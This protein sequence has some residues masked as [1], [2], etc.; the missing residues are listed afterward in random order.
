MNWTRGWWWLSQWVLVL[1]RDII[2][3]VLVGLLLGRLGETI[4]GRV[5]SSVPLDHPHAKYALD[6]LW[7]HLADEGMVGE[8]MPW[9]SQNCRRLCQGPKCAITSRE[10]SPSRCSGPQLKVG[11]KVFGEA[12]LGA[13]R[14]TAGEGDEFLWLDPRKMMLPSSS[15]KQVRPRPCRTVMEFYR[16]PCLGKIVVLFSHCPKH[17]RA[18][19]R[20][21]VEN[22]YSS[23]PLVFSIFTSTI[24]LAPR[25]VAFDLHEWVLY[26][27]LRM[28]HV[29]PSDSFPAMKVAP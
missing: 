24:H 26:Y 29:L 15:S 6:A 21:P 25:F 5:G 8:L 28:V 19:G 20:V 27:C 14:G 9:S 4:L 2:R 18:L 22:L 11:P 12:L 10:K 3:N 13:L 17:A 1:W 7:R 23:A 16:S